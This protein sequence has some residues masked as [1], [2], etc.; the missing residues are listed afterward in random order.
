M[1][2][3]IPMN[4]EYLR[5]YYDYERNHWWFRVREKIIRQQIN[6]SLPSYKPLKIL[7]AGCAT[8]RSSEMLQQY[9]EV[10]SVEKDHDVCVFLREKLNMEVWEAGLESLPFD[11][12]FFDVVC[13]FDVIEHIAEQELAVAE[14]FRVCKPGGFFYCSVPAFSFLWSIHDEVNHHKRRYTKRSLRCVLDKKFVIEY[15]TY[16]NFILFFP[17]WLSRCVLQRMR[18][19]PGMVSDFES[20]KILNSRFFSFFF[21]SLFSIE[22]LLLRYFTLPFGVSILLRA[23]KPIL[24]FQD[25]KHL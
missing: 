6:S 9:G 10:F 1:T 5:K 20:G 15:N 24:L 4:P 19:S 23:R 13:V 18:K 7:N 8:G 25:D 3:Y 14:L 21:K 22:L 17:V 2:E 12:D 16:F 11:D